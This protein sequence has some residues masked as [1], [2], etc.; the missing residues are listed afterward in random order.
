VNTQA[1]VPG[2]NR[3]DAY[4]IK[5]P[6]PSLSVQEEIVAE[7]EGYQKIIDGARQ[8]VENYKP[9]IDIDPKWEMVELNSVCDVRDGTHDSPKYQQ[10]DG[11]PL[12]TSKNVKDGKIDFTDVNLISKE[13]LDKIN[14]RSKV[15]DG[16]IIMPMIGTIGNPVVV[17]KDRDF[18]IKNVALIKF[19]TDSKIDHI[20]L[21]FILDSEYFNQF[22]QSQASGSTQKF[23][24]LGF[25][26]S[27]KIPL[28]CIETQQ[29]I[30]SRIEKEQELVNANKRL[31]EIFEQKIK[32][33]IAKV[34]GE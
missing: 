11:F 19:F 5:I 12:I 28:P 29:Q 18:A 1:G 26:R 2:L 34:W 9:R 25:I 32:D 24:P 20:Y 3:N 15:D 7:I 17:K 22:Y 10:E 16:D 6:L 21:R 30:V 14:Q 23:I 33:R 4:K 27:I 8:V 31:I 13:D